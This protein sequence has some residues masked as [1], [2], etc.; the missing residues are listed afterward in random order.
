[1]KERDREKEEEGEVK[2]KREKKAERL[3]KGPEEEQVCSLPGS[4]VFPPPFRGRLV[5]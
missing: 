5:A 3:R 4:T 1:M 2:E